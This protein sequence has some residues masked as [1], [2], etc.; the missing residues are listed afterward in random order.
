MFNVIIS[1]VEKKI[2]GCLLV[3]SYF[4]ESSKYNYAFYLFNDGKKIETV[5]Y[6]NNMKVDF[7]VKN[8][9]GVFYIRVYIKDIVHKNIRAY[10]SEKLS[11]DC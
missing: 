5:G 2:L 6:S 10:N 11:I 8:I 9:T 1:T 3:D 7:D 4:F